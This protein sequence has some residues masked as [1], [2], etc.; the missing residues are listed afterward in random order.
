M[1]W[2]DRVLFW[3]RLK[4]PHFTVASQ[5][6]YALRIILSESS[7]I[8][9]AASKHTQIGAVSMIIGALFV[10]LLT[11]TALLRSGLHWMEVAE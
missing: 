1:L 8:E 7:C 9:H 11:L 6:Y 3:D 2:T 4:L 10:A 5:V